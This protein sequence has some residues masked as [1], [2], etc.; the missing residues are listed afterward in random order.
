MLADDRNSILPID[1]RDGKG[2]FWTHNNE[3]FEGPLDKLL[4]KNNA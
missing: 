4:K 3:N 2:N 1:S